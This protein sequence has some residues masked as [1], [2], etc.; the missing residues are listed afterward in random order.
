MKKI[1][2]AIIIIFIFVGFSCVEEKLDFE[3]SGMVSGQ[4]FDSK[5]YLPLE[6]VSVTTN[7]ASGSVTT[8]ENGEFFL[9]NVP[10]GEV[11]VTA[12]RSGFSSG[13]VTVQVVSEEEITIEIILETSTLSFGNI[14]VGD[15]IP[16]DNSED[17]EIDVDLQWAFSSEK[18]PDSLKFNLILYESDL[19]FEVETYSELSDTVVHVADLSFET[20]YFWQVEAIYEEEV[21]HRSEVWSFSTKAHPEMTIFYNKKVA[22][23]YQVFGTDV[24]GSFEEQ[25]TTGSFDHFYPHVVGDGR[26]IGYTAFS[27]DVPFLYVYDTEKKTTN[28]V[29][30]HPLLGYNNVGQSFCWS[31]NGEQLV[32][33]YFA[34]MYLVN[35]DG[36]GLQKVATAPS[37]YSFKHCDWSSLNQIVVQTVGVESYDNEI[38]VM[39]TDSFGMTLLVEDVA[40][41]VESPTF[42]ADGLTV[43]YVVDDSGANISDGML[44]AQIVGIVVDGGAAIYLTS[45]KDENT[46][47]L[48]PSVSSSGRH[49]VF[50]NAP[51]SGSED[52]DLYVMDITGDNRVLLVEGVRTCSFGS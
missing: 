41:R 39:D 48:Y 29:S 14:D 17:W 1:N 35:R 30:Q 10:A 19:L 25:L 7:P 46:N 42:T 34:D 31:H 40:G 33:S 18:Y 6:G 49:V 36:T 52:G 13:S 22:G 20:T 28:K 27:N 8:N 50:V 47:D 26:Y 24:D 44:D 45:D 5:T 38:Y 4:I 43:L 2:L 15:Q 12:K 21:V 32:Y 9:E 23:F 37:G 11:V 3:T 51:N 16:E